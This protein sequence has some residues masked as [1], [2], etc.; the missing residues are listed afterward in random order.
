[1]ASMELSSS[2]SAEIGV[3]LDLRRVSQVRQATCLV[4]W[5]TGD[6]PI[7][8]RGESGIILSWF[9]IHRTISHS[10]GDI[11]V[12][13]DLWGCSWGL[14]AVPSSKSRL[15]TCLTGN[16]ELLC[17]QFRGFRS[18]VSLWGSLMFSLKMG[19]EPG[20]YSRVMAGI[21]IQNSCLFSDVR[22]PV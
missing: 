11:S 16:L 10:F 21:A 22:T 18:P 15:L 14:S 19:R 3:P 17:M 4:W 9:G 1:M 20:V 8:N 5:V 13:L 2:S 12:I 6:C 7:S